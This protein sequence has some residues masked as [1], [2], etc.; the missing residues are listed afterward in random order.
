[1]AALELVPK[2][3]SMEIPSKMT[4]VEINPEIATVEFALNKAV[5]NAVEIA[6]ETTM[7]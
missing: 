7:V 6:P 3:A 4:A 2:K 5:V 1:M